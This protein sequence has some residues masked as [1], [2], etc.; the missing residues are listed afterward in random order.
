MNGEMKLDKIIDCCVDV[1][2]YIY[3]FLIRIIVDRTRNNVLLYTSVQIVGRSF[4]LT[5]CG[6]FRL[7]TRNVVLLLSSGFRRLDP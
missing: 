6:F 7:N 2:R 4:G 5:C 3:I 1:P